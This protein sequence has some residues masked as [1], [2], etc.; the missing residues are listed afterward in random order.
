MPLRMGNR[1]ASRVFRGDGL[2][3]AESWGD[4]TDSRIIAISLTRRRVAVSR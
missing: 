1:R 4:S 2:G 3:T